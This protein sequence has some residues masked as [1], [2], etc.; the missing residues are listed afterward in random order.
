LFGGC[1]HSPVVLLRCYCGVN[2]VLRW[3][4][5]D[6]TVVFLIPAPWRV[7]SDVRAPMV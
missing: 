3:C 2:V 4:C 6:V 1:R 7:G 5:Y